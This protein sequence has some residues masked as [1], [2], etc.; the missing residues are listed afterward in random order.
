MLDA[1]DKSTQPI[2]I[3]SLLDHMDWMTDRMINEEMTHL[4]R[5]MDMKR[6]KIFWRTFAD[7]VHSSVLSWLDPVRVDDSDDRVGMYWTTWIS[8]LKNV[9]IAYEDRIVTSQNEGLIKNFITG[10][11][12]VSFPLWKPIVSASLNV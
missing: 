2:T 6:G 3:A 10:M 5:K 7:E 8:E 1:I 4:M 12:I 9:P 11:K